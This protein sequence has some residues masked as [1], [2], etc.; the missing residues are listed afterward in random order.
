MTVWRPCRR[1]PVLVA[2]ARAQTGARSPPAPNAQWTPPP[3]PDPRGA[4]SRA[5]DGPSWLSEGVFDDRSLAARRR[6]DRVL[7]AAGTAG[8][9]ETIQVSCQVASDPRPGMP[10][11]VAHP[12]RPAV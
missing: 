11:V 2:R 10:G 9:R 4:E 3:R 1:L 7:K 8:S 5:S 12:L 6:M